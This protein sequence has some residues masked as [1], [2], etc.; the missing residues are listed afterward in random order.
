MRSKLNLPLAHL[1]RYTTEA[2]AWQQQERKLGREQ[3]EAL[4]QRCVRSA[5]DGVQAAL[6]EKW[7]QVIQ[8]NEK[9]RVA[10]YEPPEH[11]TEARQQA[12]LREAAQRFRLALLACIEA[13]GPPPEAEDAQPAPELPGVP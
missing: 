10:F 6:W 4:G 5:A 9:A 1:F 8:I 13:G 11:W 3:A 12:L 7:G 2:A